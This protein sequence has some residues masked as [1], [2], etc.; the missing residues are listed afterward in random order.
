MLS[1]K[2][3]TILG[4]SALAGS[5]L[6]T[7][8]GVALAGDSTITLNAAPVNAVLPDGQSV[9]MWGYTCVSAVSNDT[10]AA[11]VSCTAANGKP[12]TG[13]WQPP[14]I[15][16]PSGKLTI[17]LGNQLT[18]NG[19]KIPTSLVIVGQLGG[20]LGAV[21]TT[22]PAI[23]HPPQ[24]TTWPGT[25]GDTSDPGATFTPP[26]QSDRVQSFATEVQAGTSASLCWGSTC[27]GAGSH[28]NLRPGTYLIES[29]THPSIQGPMGLYG[30]LVV[31]DASYP[32]VPFDA[33]VALLLSEIDPVQNQA[34]SD[35]VG[36]SGF[37]EAA[38]RSLRSADAL[39]SI[40]VTD[41]GAGYTSAPAV[42][43]DA[44]PCVVNGTTC[45]QAT[46]AASVNGD[47][48]V[49]AI[50]L[51]D[52]GAGYTLTPNV[53]VSAPPAGPGSATATA[54]AGQVTAGSSSC[55]DASRNV[56][57]ACYP[58]AVNYDPRYY[59]INGIS[60]DRTR[61]DA[62]SLAIGAGATN[63]SVLL[64]FVNA[65]LR[66][67]VPS[68]V[69]A[70][71]SLHAEDGN[72]LP[73]IPRIQDEVLLPAGKTYDV[74]ISPA[75]DPSG[76]YAAATYAVFD[77]Q[78]SLST[79]NQRD[80]GMIAHLTVGG[81]AG[82][83]SATA[84]VND[85][86]YSV[87]PGT[88]LTVSDIARGVMANDVGVY[89]VQLIGTVTGLAFHGNGTFTY[90]AAV[91]PSTFT[92]CANGTVS[93][94][95][96]SG[97]VGTVHVSV[98][99]T[100]CLGVPSAVA[101]NYTSD[102]ASRLQVS[103]PGVLGND[104]DTLGMPLTA[105]LGTVTHGTVIL[106]PDGA[107]TASPSC[108]PNCPSGGAI[109]AVSF[110]YTASNSQ[111]A[112]ATAT[113]TVNFGAPSGLQ[114]TLTDGKSGAVLPNDYRWII[115]E[116]RT[117]H[118]DP[119]AET[120]DPSTP[121]RNLGVN[122]HTSHT[123][124]VAAGCVGALACETG[125]TVLG[126]PAACDVGNGAC[127][128]DSAHK[129]AVR[130][131]QVHLDPTKRYYLSILPGTG[132][133]DPDDSTQATPHSMGGVQIAPG[134]TAVNVSVQALPLPTAKIS[135]FV[136]E[137][138]NP[139]N[140]ENDTGGGVDV[141]APNEPG[142]EGFHI[143]LLDQTG[144]FG[145]PAGQL[146]YDEFGEP[147]SNSLA[148]TIDPTTGRD[149]C[150]I[151]PTSTDG[152]VGMIVTCPKY[153]G[154]LPSDTATTPRVL[155]PLAGHAIIANMYPGL[156]E[157]HTTP[158]ADRTARGEEWLQ[159]NTLDGTKDIEAFIKAEEPA[160]FQEFGPGGYHVAVGFANPEVINARQAGVRS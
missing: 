137:D 61:A 135:V 96:C 158:G 127:R 121:V 154:S 93:G 145:D 117:V 22:T 46:G 10:P 20:G 94:S 148:G 82:P 128:T 105:A 14:L 65:G 2:I 134:Q 6:L 59:L 18:F 81:G 12:Q 39:A 155:S 139:L 122:F 54:A 42:T 57:A 21:R 114:V 103:P 85:D 67:H 157:V 123:P 124:V 45:V 88:T 70:S 37:S 149:A 86:N 115:E 92:Y 89:G 142:L 13:G 147:V 153:E 104:S 35:A 53:H 138:D 78:L 63:G 28:A 112:S 3:K 19:N 156:Y 9:P 71:M 58:P 95:S 102:I 79:N 32:G 113:A 140:G 7:T 62:S 52:A 136:F 129:V 75:K 8:G 76:S 5:I 118:I 68:V 146:T 97:I 66:A 24:G 151:S 130:P 56:V 1:E 50:E 160:Y 49:D 43:I 38:T 41:G 73:G 77:R 4:T 90:T 26:A 33:D 133:N 44:P 23:A 98:C 101:D 60:F 116:D 74:T 51:T 72:V 16:V 109:A 84:S 29:G 27:S 48:Q 87:V 30:V 120:N 47:G 126:E 83:G 55:I 119:V 34:V 108:S 152:L 110:E 141:L 31:T 99:D 69:G 144:Q 40:F 11:A 125:Q 111:G 159:T 17:N 131:S 36:I 143:V 107:F 91:A 100:G 106:N 64:R 15:R 132:A 150:P 25:P 80:G